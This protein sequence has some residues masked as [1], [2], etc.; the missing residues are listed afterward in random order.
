MSS[1][2]PDV[3]D[4]HSSRL[5]HAGNTARNEGRVHIR[6]FA[7]IIAP[8]AALTKKEWGATWTRDQVPDT[9]VLSSYNYD[10]TSPLSL[11]S[12]RRSQDCGSGETGRLL[13]VRH[14]QNCQK[15]CEAV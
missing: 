1:K 5:F 9:Q 2:I 4:A 10:F 15:G 14:A 11:R 3:P 6:N 12:P 8:L 7:H 13:V